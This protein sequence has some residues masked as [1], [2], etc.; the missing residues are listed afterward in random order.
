VD[1]EHVPTTWDHIAAW[2]RPRRYTLVRTAILRL[3]GFIYV[4]AFLGIAFQGPALLGSHGL[5]PIASAVDGVSFRDVPSIFVWNSSDWFLSACAWLGVAISIAVALG[6][7]NLPMLVIL[8]VLYGSYVRVGQTWYAFGWET[9]ILETTLIAAVIAHPWDVR[10][11][12]A[13]PPPVAAIVAMRWLAFRIMLGAGLIKWRGSACW[14]D[15]TCLDWHFETQ[16]IPNPLSPWF[17]HLPH[18]VHAIGVVFNHVVELGAPWLAFGPRRLRLAAALAML[19]FQCVLIASGNLA[20][21]N[22]L[23][24]IP[25]LACFD[26]DAL[27]RVIPRRAR[28]WIDARIP[29]A[30]PRDASQLVA[31]LAVG[32]WVTV[33][34]TK[35]LHSLG[36]VFVVLAGAY[37]VFRAIQWAA[38]GRPPGA[39]PHRGGGGVA[40][41]GAGQ[42]R[43]GVEY[44]AAVDRR[45]AMNTSYDNLEL[46]NTYG[47]FG[48]VDEVRHELVIEGT[49]AADPDAPDAKWLA[50][51]LPCKPGDVARRPCILGPYHRRLDWLI[52]F[53][54]MEDQPHDAWIVHLI[55]KLLD[56]DPTIRE[57]LAVDPFDGVAPRWVRIRRF[58]YHLEPYSSSTWWTRDSEQLWIPPVS[59]D[60]PELREVLDRYG[61]SAEE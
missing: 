35:F 41:R 40:G 10:P 5:T 15:L 37:G 23:T 39:A 43:A 22:W 51:E 52:W 16:P 24:V 59:R 21:L 60:T 4:F 18:A 32:A 11:L 8:W 54:A 38:R 30:P 12:A 3:L 6:Y 34:Y 9:Q 44:L 20:F 19:A 47:A 45:Q 29:N 56:G 58:V 57:L 13:R 2:F 42:N 14:H 53:S 26:D 61:W 33:A 27:R 17:H 48:S 46:V 50:Y 25:I 31:G 36:W 55:W 49:M 7:A 1:V 28:A